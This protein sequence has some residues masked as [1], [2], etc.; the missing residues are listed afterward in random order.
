MIS[1]SSARLMN[2]PDYGIEV[3]A[4]A[5]MVVLDA[6]DPAM[7]VA[8]LAQPL[9]GF[10]AGRQVFTRDLPKLHGPD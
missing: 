8:E 5:D 3:G 10:K 2:L 9:Y 1:G 6:T 7:A 4:K